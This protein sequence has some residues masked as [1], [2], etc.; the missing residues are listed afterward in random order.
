MPVCKYMMSYKVSADQP[1]PLIGDEDLS[2]EDCDSSGTDVCD[3]DLTKQVTNAEN[4]D[5]VLN[6]VRNTKP[7]GVIHPTGVYSKI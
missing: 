7:F 6:T 5:R 2:Q 3:I 1:T 4:P